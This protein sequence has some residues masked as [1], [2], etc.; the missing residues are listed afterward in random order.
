LHETKCDVARRG[1]G[2]YDGL[3]GYMARTRPRPLYFIPEVPITRLYPYGVAV[4]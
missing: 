1:L 3:S 4:R 2:Y